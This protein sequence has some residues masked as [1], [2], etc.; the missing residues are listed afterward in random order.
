MSENQLT[1]FNKEKLFTFLGY[2]WTLDNMI[3]GELADEYESLNIDDK[4]KFR[5]EIITQLELDPQNASFIK[6]YREI[7]QKIYENSDNAK[8]NEIYLEE[9]IELCQ[10]K[11]KSKRLEI[12]D[13]LKICL[14]KCSDKEILDFLQSINDENENIPI[15]NANKN[16]IE[17]KKIWGKY[18]KEIK[19]DNFNPETEKILQLDFV[20]NVIDA[21][22][23]ENIKLELKTYANTKSDNFLNEVANYAENLASPQLN[24]TEDNDD[25]LG[26]KKFFSAVGEVV[27]PISKLIL[28]FIPKKTS[29][30]EITIDTLPEK[31][32]SEEASAQVE[33]ERA[34]LSLTN[35]EILQFLQKQDLLREK[36][37]A[38]TFTQD[39]KSELLSVEKLNEHIKVLLDNG[40]DEFLVNPDSS[41][42]NHKLIYAMV[43]EDL[44][45][46]KNALE[47][48]A[49]IEILVKGKDIL[50][51]EGI[52][53][54]V[55]NN[56][57]L[58]DYF[59]N[60]HLF[61]SVE[62]PN[63]NLVVL[64]KELSDFWEAK[65]GNGNTLLHLAC[66]Q[67]N[68]A[69][70]TQL[71]IAKDI[72]IG[73]KNKDGKIALELI[74]D[75]DLKSSICRMALELKSTI[76]YDPAVKP[77]LKLDSETLSTINNIL[78]SI[79]DPLTNISLPNVLGDPFKPIDRLR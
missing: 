50:H 8:L 41:M 26:L 28:K 32:E 61:T 46:A 15:D 70:I 1:T 71:L 25:S 22:K 54:Y 76:E 3:F 38:G 66:Q 10:M 63:S 24:I 48:G 5:E 21:V 36:F 14:E 2:S 29:D 23:D 7:E 78:K 74:E 39:D 60:K 62:K 9:I 55:A 18:K 27:K 43:N 72:D 67:G 75:K 59:Q 35:E 30:S 58:I 20:L 16:S 4:G 77:K 19:T 40:S 17:L 56:E 65:D 69:V 53:R 79:T 47:N 73:I 57:N 34:D 45:L 6:D 44:E 33:Q 31:I 64:K 42:K 11:N 52:L 51:F 13:D 37:I 12:I 68:D 49:S